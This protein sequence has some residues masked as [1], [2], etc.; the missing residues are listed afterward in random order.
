MKATDWQSWWRRHASWQ[1]YRAPQ[2][3]S[4]SLCSEWK[5]C[6]VLNQKALPGF[7]ILLWLRISVTAVPGARPSPPHFP[8]PNPPTSP[9]HFCPLAIQRGRFCWKQT[10]TNKRPKWGEESGRGCWGRTCVW[11]NC[12]ETISNRCLFG[13]GP[14]LVSP[15]NIVI[16]LENKQCEM[17]W[18]PAGPFGGSLM[19]PEGRR[20]VG[21]KADQRGCG[22]GG[23]DRA[24]KSSPFSEEA[25][26]FHFAIRIKIQSQSSHC[27]PASVQ[28]L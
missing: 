27:A 2:C 6:F 23:Q 12:E 16:W 3:K 4:C 26:F 28:R 24:H 17:G 5:T 1:R 15:L 9:S 18:R 13:L 19:T 20:V 21:V 8:T 14:G 7:P 22:A 25:I 11:N 10:T